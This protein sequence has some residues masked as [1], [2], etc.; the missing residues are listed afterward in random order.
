MV[1]RCI[2]YSVSLNFITESCL[3]TAHITGNAFA[4]PMLL[5]KKPITEKNDRYLSFLQDK[6]NI[7]HHISI[8][9]QLLF[10]T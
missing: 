6:R 10:R 4:L 7:D 5:A 3:K 9:V 8:N 2:C 1:N